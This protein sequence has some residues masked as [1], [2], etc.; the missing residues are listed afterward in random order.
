MSSPAL[1]LCG[2]GFAS[3]DLTNE[4]LLSAFE[5]ATS[6]TDR[7]RLGSLLIT[8]LTRAGHDKSL[9]Q[10]VEL[11]AQRTRFTLRPV[12]EW[13]TNLNGGQTDKP[14]YFAGFPFT[15]AEEDQ[16]RAGL[17]LG[18]ELG[19]RRRVLPGNGH[20]IDVSGYLTAAHAPEEDL[21]LIRARASL[22]HTW[23]LDR[24]KALNSCLRGTH[25]TRDLS[26]DDAVIQSVALTRF[27]REAG[28]G[29]TG[30]TLGVERR[31]EDD[32]DQITLRG[33]LERAARGDLVLRATYGRGWFGAGEFGISETAGLSVARPIA[34]RLTRVSYSYVKQDDG[35]V[36]FQDR[37]DRAHSISLEV[38]AIGQTFVQFGYVVRESSIS[39]FEDSYPTLGL[40]LE[41]LKF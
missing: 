35:E 41:P 24:H 3:E 28:T 36:L 19:A 26:Q 2:R 32:L 13:S 37:T 31:L 40:R 15:F 27:F 21:S 23:R 10:D 33:T 25:Q 14:I 18:A 1:A 5:A 11:P 9:G 39:A 6:A 16:R 4:C 12:L 20:R 7:R 34:D 38:Q 8:R 17:A 30:L 22:C 29:A